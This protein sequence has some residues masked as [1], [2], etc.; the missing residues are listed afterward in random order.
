MCVRGGGA[1]GAWL[2]CMAYPPAPCRLAEAQHRLTTLRGQVEAEGLLKS[3]EGEWQRLREFR[4][5]S[6][7]RR[8]QASGAVRAVA[9]VADDEGRDV[10]AAVAGEG[11]DVA[12]AVIIVRGGSSG[13][14]VSGGGGQQPA[15]PP[16]DDCSAKASALPLLSAVVHADAGDVDILCE[17]R[18]SLGSKISAHKDGGV[19]P[20]TGIACLAASSADVDRPRM[21]PGARTATTA[22]N[23]KAHAEPEG[24]GASAGAVGGAAAQQGGTARLVVVRGELFQGQSILRGS[25][26]AGGASSGRRVS[27]TMRL[28]LGPTIAYK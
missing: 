5:S 15:L 27:F 18:L 28:D 26:G 9:A 10:S 24:A 2:K 25:C 7:L 8:G 19:A 13:T 12:A 1:H 4:A 3:L 23:G 21:S 6:L 11:T 22:G 17:M 14:P 16:S 20:G